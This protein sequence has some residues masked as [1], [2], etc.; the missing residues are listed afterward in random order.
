MATTTA[1]LRNL[2]AFLVFAIVASITLWH[3]ELWRDELQAF[4]IARNSQSLA[5]LMANKVYEGHPL[6]WYLMLY[7]ITR[8]TQSIFA[9]QIVNLMLALGG[10]WLLV[11]YF[12][13]KSWIKYL[14]M[15]GYFFLY[16]YT[17]LSRN[18]AIEYALTF[19][20]L[21]SLPHKRWGLSTLLLCLLMQTNAFGFLIAAALLPII[22]SLQWPDQKKAAGITLLFFVVSALFFFITVQPPSDSGFAPGWSFHLTDMQKAVNKFWDV[23]LPIPSCTIHS[24]NSNFLNTAPPWIKTILSISLF[25][26]ACFTLR[27]SKSALAFFITACVLIWLFLSSK[28]LG[29]LRH[30]GHYFIAFVSALWL[31]GQKEDKSSPSQFNF[32]NLFIGSI[33]SV[34]V[35]AGIIACYMD[36]KYPFSNAQKVAAYINKNY[37]D[38]RLAATPDYIGASIGILLNK[39]VYYP[40]SNRVGQFIIWDNKR[41]DLEEGMEISL[42]GRQKK[43]GQDILLLSGAI[44]QQTD[45]LNAC[46]FQL[47][48]SFPPAIVK[49]E[50]YFLYK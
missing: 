45:S 50:Q 7:A 30:Q 29:F 14:L 47:I 49:N 46:G 11:H 16:E 1:G 19:A 22:M 9:M 21:A 44:L 28:Y 12:P 8:F 39:E 27:K 26:V 6:L 32:S 43:L 23:F 18:Y 38:T 10:I 2:F 5:Q 48:D 20:L 42:A 37:P 33:L 17:I 3:H 24:W 40:C 41:L 35:A 4:G 36:W 34:Q 25:A 31:A 15:F 13:S